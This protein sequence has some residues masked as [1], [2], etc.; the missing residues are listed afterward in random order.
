MGKKVNKA[1]HS[2]L[3]VHSFDKCLLRVYWVPSGILDAGGAA[4]L[5]DVSVTFAPGAYILIRLER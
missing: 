3:F 5:R 2:L 1:H 4:A